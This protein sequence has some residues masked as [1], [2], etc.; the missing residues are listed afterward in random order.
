[1]ISA[2]TIIARAEDYL[3]IGEN[4][5]IKNG[6]L[7]KYSK[8]EVLVRPILREYLKSIGEYT[9]DED[10]GMDLQSI[11]DALSDGSYIF[12]DSKLLTR[13]WGKGKD[14]GSSSCRFLRN[15]ITHEL[16]ER[17]LHEVVERTDCLNADM[18]AF[19]EVLTNT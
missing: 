4:R 8:C 2:T 19:I 18:D 3:S 16:M 11:K 14:K 7:E 5:S 12:D 10:L 6:F 1:M 13:I 15:K 9:S 17:A